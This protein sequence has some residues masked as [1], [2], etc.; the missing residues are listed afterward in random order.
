MARYS[1]ASQRKC[2][3]ITLYCRVITVDTWLCRPLILY[4]LH[5]RLQPHR[6]RWIMGDPE[7]GRLCHPIRPK[8]RDSIYHPQCHTL[9][10]VHPEN[11]SYEWLDSTINPR[12][13]HSP[14]NPQIS[15][16]G[17]NLSVTTSPQQQRE[18]S[19]QKET[20]ITAEVVF[21]Y[22]KHE[23]SIIYYHH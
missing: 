8:R 15:S 7:N 14:H 3:P 19:D 10:Y 2:S 9:P 4:T 11:N 12:V 18:W 20:K 6:N 23:P 16:Y 22:T 1:I 5:C 21:V 13:S 17:G